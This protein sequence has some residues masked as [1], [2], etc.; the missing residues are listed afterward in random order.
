MLA[1]VVLISMWAVSIQASEKPSRSTEIIVPFTEYEWWLIRWSTNQPEC[2]ILADH[3]GFPTGDDVL[4]FCGEDIYEEWFET[5]S[6]PEAV[7]KKG[8][9]AS[10]KGL[11]LHLI[12]ETPQEQIVQVDLPT[13]EAWI[14]LTGCTPVLPEN[15]CETLPSLLFIGEEPLPN[16]AIIQIQGTFN[17]I[18]FVC[19]PGRDL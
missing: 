11:Y 6:C 8:D 5:E 13:A 1:S 16:E 10:C 9:T 3:D 14:N 17:S 4:I 18:P 12:T 15:R 7:S 19:P 2:R